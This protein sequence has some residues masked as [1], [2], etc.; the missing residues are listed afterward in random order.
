MSADVADAASRIASAPAHPPGTLG[1][2]DHAPGVGRRVDVKADLRSGDVL[3]AL[4]TAADGA[5]GPHADGLRESMV[6]VLRL[7]DQRP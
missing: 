6:I 2:E 7:A 3:A 5:T 4:A 1:A